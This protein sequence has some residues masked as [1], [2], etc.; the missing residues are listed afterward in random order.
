MTGPSIGLA[1]ESLSFTTAGTREQSEMVLVW[2]LLFNGISNFM[3]YFIQN[4]F[5]LKKSNG[6][7]NL[8][9]GE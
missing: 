4:P 7:F 9:L 6:L 2:F 3:G 8:L 5:W 1:T